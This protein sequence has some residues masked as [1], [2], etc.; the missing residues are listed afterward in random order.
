MRFCVA[1]IMEREMHAP[2]HTKSSTSTTITAV[3]DSA[4]FREPVKDSTLLL[5]R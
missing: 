1:G 3:S 5:R 2:Q 4:F